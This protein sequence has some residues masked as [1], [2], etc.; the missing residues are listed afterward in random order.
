MLLNAFG[1]YTSANDMLWTLDENGRLTMGETT[2]NYKMDLK[3]MHKLYEDGC[4]DP[5]SFI[6][7]RDEWKAKAAN[8]QVALFTDGA[9]GSVHS[10]GDQYTPPRTLPGLARSPA[11]TALSRRLRGRTMR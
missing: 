9:I 5:K 10:K 6:Q 8:E 2:E 3:Y 1:I 11:S 4:I 7:T